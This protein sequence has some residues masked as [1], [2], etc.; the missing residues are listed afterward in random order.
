M[1]SPPW[2]M[3]LCGDG[4]PTRHLQL[5]TGCGQA[6]A[7][8]S[9]QPRA[10]Q[11]EQCLHSTSC[12]APQRALTRREGLG[13]QGA[14]CGGG[15]GDGGGR[16]R[17]GGR[18]QGDC[19]GGEAAAPAPGA[20]GGAGLRALAPRLGA[21][22]SPLSPPSPQV[23]LQTSSGRRLGYATSWWNSEE[24][25]GRASPRLGSDPDRAPPRAALTAC[26]GA[27]Q[28]KSHLQNTNLPIWKSLSGRKTEIFREILGAWRGAGR[29][30][31]GCGG[32]RAPALTRG[33]CAQ[34]CIAGAARR[35]GKGLAWRRASSGA[36]T[37]CSGTA[38][39]RCA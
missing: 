33:A 8:P 16:Q 21:H 34:A 7:P 10:A 13:A 35:C 36:G 31:H 14:H 26:P 6:A 2:Q 30:R 24:V 4:S 12:V 15:S 1:L 22:P 28:V 32:R 17:R 3:F 19:D 11:G 20:P 39:S 5:L 9:R 37:T 25:C 18:A 38:G 29:R 23:W 27:E